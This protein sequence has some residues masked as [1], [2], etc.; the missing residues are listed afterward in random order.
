MKHDIS[1]ILEHYGG[2]VVP[3]R[4]GWHK[5]KCPFHDDSHASAVVNTEINAF[6][7]FGCGVKGDTYKIIMEKEGVE[8]REAIT[9]AERVTGK[10]SDSLP[11]FNSSSRRVSSGSGIIAKRRGYSPPRASR[12]TANGT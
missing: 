7:C 5:M 3:D 4:Y 2:K 12:R 9:F 10:S 6:A 1:L 11:K 8:F